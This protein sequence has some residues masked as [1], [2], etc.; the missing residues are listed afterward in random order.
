MIRLPLQGDDDTII[1]IISDITDRIHAEESIRN[2]QLHLE[3]LVEKR[4]SDLKL[5][6]E[7]LRQV[8]KMEAV[9][10]IAGG[11]AHD[12]NNILSGIVSYPDLLLLDLPEDSP[13][14][15]P[16]LSIKR[17]GEKAAATVQDLLTL[18]RSGV[19][20]NEVL[21]LNV[22][23]SEYLRSPEYLK[24][25]SYHLD[26]RVESSL[27]KGLFNMQGS[28]VHLSKILMNLVSNAAEATPSGGKILISTENRYI[29]KGIEGYE[30]ISPGEYVVLT[31]ADTGVGISQAD[32]GRVFEPFFTKKMTGRSGTGLG[33]AVVWKTVKDHNAYIDIHSAESKG[34]TFKL[35]FPITRQASNEKKSHIAIESYM[36]KGESV[37]IV[38][39]AEEQREILSGILKRLGYLVSSV[40]SGE[41]AVAYLT[42]NAADLIVLDMIME[43]GIDG[44]ETY[45][46]ILELH[47]DQKSIIASGFSETER[48]QDTLKLGAGHY[49]KKPHTLEK[50]GVVVRSELDK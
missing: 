9:G 35:Y 45:R 6:N 16:I 1:V 29:D 2:Y 17:S 49:I 38:D 37:L 23:I 28:A 43:P 25:K 13:L 21:N 27:D 41:E 48:I 39:D 44:L 11:I 15:K 50:I 8:Q 7:R 30:K 14:R 24:M 40:S 22:I 4:T 19:V 47:P 33:M 36:G 31:V 10:I 34:T 20:V 32:K 3:T 46:R 18:A 42:E 12:L 5:A 26:V